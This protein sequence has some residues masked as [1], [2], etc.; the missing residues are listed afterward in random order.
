MS[1]ITV[2][3]NRKVCKVHIG[4]LVLI[5][6]NF[7]IYFFKIIL[8]AMRKRPCH[9]QSKRQNNTIFMGKKK[10]F[11]I[12]YLCLGWEST[13]RAGVIFPFYGIWHSILWQNRTKTSQMPRCFDETE[14]VSPWLLQNY[15]LIFL[16][17]LTHSGLHFLLILYFWK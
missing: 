9:K 5:S 14:D 1:L 6:S 16:S 8:Q 7:W 3:P 12:L 17:S 2:E 10:V 13:W 11:W 15:Y 4:H